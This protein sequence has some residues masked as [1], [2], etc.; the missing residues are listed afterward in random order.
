MPDGINATM[1]QMQAA[2][3]HAAIHGLR[4]QPELK[5]LRARHDAALPARSERDLDV[6]GDLPPHA[7]V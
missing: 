2:D 4:M 7:E 5:E 1:D 6:P 3:L